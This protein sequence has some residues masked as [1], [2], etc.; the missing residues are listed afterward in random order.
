[1][2]EYPRYLEALIPERGR[3]K[4]VRSEAEKYAKSHAPEDC[5]SMGMALYASEFKSRRPAFSCW[6]SPRTTMPRP[7]PTWNTP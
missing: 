6:A 2:K 4:L 5:V 3:L 1:M 7:W